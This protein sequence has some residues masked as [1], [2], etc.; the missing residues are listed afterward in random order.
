MQGA[1]IIIMLSQLVV[2]GTALC[3]SMYWI[4]LSGSVRLEFCVKE[5][6]SKIAEKTIKLSVFCLFC[7]FCFLQFSIRTLLI[8]NRILLINIIFIQSA[9]QGVS[10]NF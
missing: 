1:F 5:V 8:S 4:F 3:V 9:V 10:C 2:C 6:Y 7:L